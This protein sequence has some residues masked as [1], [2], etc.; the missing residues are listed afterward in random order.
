MSDALYEQYEREL[1]FIREA[2]QDFARK[3]PA[4]AGRLL[5]EQHG[6]ADPHVERLIE[7]FSFLAARVQQKLND[8]F[9][10]LTDAVLNVLYPH[11]LAPFPSMATVEFEPDAANT[12]PEGLV[13]P[14]G[15]RLHSQEIVD[16]RCRFRT[17]YPVTLW[18]LEVASARLQPTPFGE[19]FRAPPDCA[20]ALIL[21]FR[22][23][24]GTPIAQLQTLDRLRL[25]LAS[26][27][28]TVGPLY[29]LIF[30]DALRVDFWSDKR[31]LASLSPEESLRQA[32]F[33]RDEGLLPYRPQSFLGYRLL[34][35]FFT[36]PEKFHYVDLAGWDR[37]VAASPGSEVECVIFL[38]RS[39]LEL[40]RE[41]DNR[42]FRLGGTPAVNLFEK[43]AEPI[44][45]T[46]TKAEYRVIA[47][48]HRQR[49][50][51]VYSID[52]VVGTAGPKQTTYHPFYAF[53]HES[54]WTADRDERAYWYSVR[55]PSLAADDPGTEVFL[56]LV[57]LDFDP[58]REA[59]TVLTVRTTCTNRDLP[60][61]LHRAG[62]SLELKPEIAVPVRAV[63]CL[64][65]PTPTRRPALGNRAYWRLISH[66]TLN[67]LSLVDP[68][69]GRAS[70]QEML[71]LYSHFGAG[72]DPVQ[73]A[74]NRQL[75]DGIT[76]I[77]G[78]RVVRRIGGPVS[79]GVC[80]G[81][82]VALELD[83]QQTSGSGGFLFASVL[84][85][86][87][88]LYASVN[89]FTQ[90]RVSTAGEGG[91]VRHWPPRAGEERL[92]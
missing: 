11:Y 75:I 63:R 62:G 2:S 85:R 36:F 90:L 52:R 33:E 47:D 78:R 18:P 71:R 6:S 24:A 43:V 77:S 50:T 60:V 46:Q 66:L 49:E 41:V 89:S 87:F 44:P 58:L 54:P 15:T 84:E 25:H 92:L 86:F 27:P 42:V 23:M 26:S 79:G 70:L 74:R 17:C 20:A 83:G 30:N 48:V 57:D 29:E 81:M 76:S 21:R 53:R 82:E 80:R 64:T 9:P 7:A 51:E 55:R 73:A 1:F 14:S 56:R 12:Q 32:G 67:H 34:S 16:T 13:I 38:D 8:E 69:E 45:V 19:A 31:L 59:D 72:G 37:V 68:R 40:E 28:E 91:F 22:G 4:T 5:L 39:V 35:E 61:R 3:Y 65:P 10:E 88:A